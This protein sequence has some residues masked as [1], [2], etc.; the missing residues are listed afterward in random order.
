MP[1]IQLY[2]AWCKFPKKQSLTLQDEV[3][4]VIAFIPE[5]EI[6]PQQISCQ[7][8]VPYIHNESEIIVFVQGLFRKPKRT[9]KAR[10]AL[11][12]AIR[13]VV[14]KRFPMCFVEVFIVPFDPK[15]GFATSAD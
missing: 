15:N 4:R 5:F 12:E 9:A 2:G 7:L 14:L 13:D 11:A 8:L 1:I 6:A 3:K 10:R